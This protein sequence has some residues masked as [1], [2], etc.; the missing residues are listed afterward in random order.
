MA[1]PTDL[2]ENLDADEDTI[3]SQ[4]DLLDFQQAILDLCAENADLPLIGMIG[5]LHTAANVL[6]SN[7]F[8]LSGDELEEED[9][10][11]DGPMA[12]SFAE[13]GEPG[14]D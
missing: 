2:Q 13:E 5:A 1:D 8:D 11:E 4:G 3:C 12:V 6:T 14:E 10:A 7:I 9:E